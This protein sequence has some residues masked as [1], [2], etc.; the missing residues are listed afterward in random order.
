MNGYDFDKTIFDGD[1]FTKFFFFTI[2][3]KPL[4]ALFLPFQAVLVL[5]HLLK[6]IS[7][8]KIKEIIILNLKFF[9][10][11][12]KLVEQFW[13]KNIS[14]IKNWYLLQ[15]QEDDVIISASPEFLVKGACNKL[16][17][18]NVIGSKMDINALR[19]EGKNCWGSE[20]VV[21]FE[22]EFGKD[23]ILEAFYSDS[24]SD[25]PMMKK[26]KKGYLVNKNKIILILENK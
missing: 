6:L 14:K 18:K 13:D 4:L 8:K 10:D 16:G 20:K 9:K 2:S 25:I 24:K 19:I 12:E 22:Q 26:A 17:I 21:R 11:R 7:K 1:C 15:K 5:L 3:K 23:L